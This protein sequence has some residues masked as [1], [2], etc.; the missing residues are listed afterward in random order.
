MALGGHLDRLTECLPAGVNGM[1]AQSRCW[2]RFVSKRS[3]AI[4]LFV[5]ELSATR[6]HNRQQGAGSRFRYRL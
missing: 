1:S 4:G 2:F 6:T 5:C 3:P